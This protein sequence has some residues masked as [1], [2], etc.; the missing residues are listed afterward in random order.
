M[1]NRNQAVTTFIAALGHP[2]RADIEA[3]RG[4]I[5]A[6]DAQITE[7]IKWNAPSFG[8]RNDDRVTMRLHPGDRLQLIFHRGAKVKRGDNFTFAD[9]SGL[10]HWLAPDR[11]VVTLTDME[12]VQAHLTPLVALVN[13]WLAETR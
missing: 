10:L 1:S 3:V 9:D 13:R 12:D 2:F 7:Q 8:Y 6:S 5:L 4:A 11:A